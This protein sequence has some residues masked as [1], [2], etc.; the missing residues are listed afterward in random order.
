MRVYKHVSYGWMA[1]HEVEIGTTK[2]GLPRIIEFCT[3]KRH[4]GEVTTSAQVFEVN[5]AIGT[6]SMR[7]CWREG[8]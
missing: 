2:E 3:M 1:D 4:S 7:R 8:R 6:R 5:K